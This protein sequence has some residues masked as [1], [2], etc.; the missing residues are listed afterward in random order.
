[1]Q[2]HSFPGFPE[3]IDILTVVASLMGLHAGRLLSPMLPVQSAAESTSI[4]SEAAF[5]KENGGPLLYTLFKE[6]ERMASMIVAPL[7]DDSVLAFFSSHETFN[8]AA[9]ASITVR[10]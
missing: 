9:I 3:F 4:I 1:M 10:P 5:L 6:F 8:A 2:S 7:A